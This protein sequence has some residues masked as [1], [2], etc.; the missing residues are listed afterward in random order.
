MNSIAD[1]KHILQTVFGYDEFR[2]NQQQI[3]EEVLEGKDAVVLMPTGGGKSLCYQ[4]PALCLPGVTIVVSPLIALMKDQVDALKVNGIKAEFLNSTQNTSEQA[5]I[6]QQL[7][8]NELKLLYIAPERL[9]GNETQFIKYLQQI[10]VS[11]FAIDEAHCISQWGHDFRPEYLVL[12]QLKEHFPNLPI[13]A[14]TATADA[15]T[16]KDIIDKLRFTKYKVFENSFNRPNIYYYVK[17][18]K[19]YYEELTNYLSDHKN[20]SGIIYC[21]SRTSTERLAEDLKADGFNAEAYHAGLDKSIREERQ[22]KFLKDDIQIIVATIAF[23]MGINK[24]N[25]RFVVHIDLPKN[26]EGYYQETGRAG[27]DGLHSEALLFYSAG[28]VLKLKKFAEVEGNQEQT[29]IMLAKLDKI[30]RFCETKTC[31][32]KYLLNYFGEDAPDYCGSCDTCL[33]KPVLKEATV[34]AQKILSAVAR[35]IE[36]FGMRYVVDVL[37]GSNTEKMREEHK[38]LTVYGIGKD[39]PKEEWMHYT[40]E[41]LHFQYLEQSEGQYPVLKLTQKGKD[42]LFKKEPVYLTA[43]VHIEIPNEPV[44]YQQHPYDKDL[45]EKLKQLRNKIAHEE[46]VPPYII[47]SDS[48]LLDL[49]TYLPLTESDLLKISGFGTFKTQKYGQHFLNTIQ[50]YCFEHKLETQINLKQPKEERKH[51]LVSATE[52]NSDTKRVSFTL[53][54]QGKTIA[55]IAEERNLSINTIESHLSYFVT[56]GDLEINDLVDSNKQKAIKKAIEIYGA[57]NGLKVLK[58]NLPE[59]MTYGE[60]KMVLAVRDRGQ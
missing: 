58:E 14:L 20:N 3:I 55:E 10:N 13:I 22:N 46:N 5:F 45:F 25:V 50:D 19:N 30:S 34:I 11:L 33:N 43:P 32:R 39:M 31:R 1:P 40:K 6:F 24:S 44:V 51:K 52:R 37:K 47:F 2:H 4:V 16:Q 48:T 35:L 57:S 18:K 53:F 38:S 17:P 42:V 36:N 41:L 7:K 9:L 15:L 21:L 28:D 29:K 27:R 54:K 8:A 49:A 59:E 12:G 60:I 23:G 26:I 56:L